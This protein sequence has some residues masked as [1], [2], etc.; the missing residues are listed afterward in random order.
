MVFAVAADHPLAEAEEPITSSEILKYRAVAIADTSRQLPPRSAGLLT[1]QDVLTV[2]D[3]QSKV[4]AQIQGLG[5]GYIPRPIIQKE[6][7]AGKLITRTVEN[8]TNKIEIFAA[9][10]SD[11]KGKALKWFIDKLNASEIQNHLLSNVIG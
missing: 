1:G 10:R 9:W 4:K 8:M 2:P 5:I 7:E 6:I 3:M 11:H